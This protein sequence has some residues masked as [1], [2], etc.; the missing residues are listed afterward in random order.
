[1]SR[2]GRD[3][4]AERRG[5]KRRRRTRPSGGTQDS[6]RSRRL[7]PGRWLGPGVY[8]VNVAAVGYRNAQP[9]RRDDRERQR[10]PV[11]RRPARARPVGSRPRG[12]RE[13]QR[14]RERVGRASRRPGATSGRDI[15]PRDRRTSTGRSSSRRPPTAPIDLTAVASGFP[16]ARADG[17][18]ASRRRRRRAPRTA[19]GARPRQRARP[20]RPAGP[21]RD[22]SPTGRCP[23][24]LGANYMRMSDRTPPDRQRRHD[25]GQRRWDRARTS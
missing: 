22:A 17:R 18:S 25:D 14:N 20:D 3:G 6:T 15:A 1:M 10:R 16:P 19:A 9:P 5:R 23:T 12:G 24:F 11:A 7:V 21:R 4:H 13:R 2:R 8:K